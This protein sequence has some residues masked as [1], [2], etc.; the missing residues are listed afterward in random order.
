MYSFFFLAMAIVSDSII[1][2]ISFRFYDM[3]ILQMYVSG[4]ELEVIIVILTLS[5]W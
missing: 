4:H 5:S 3:L 1:C 2:F